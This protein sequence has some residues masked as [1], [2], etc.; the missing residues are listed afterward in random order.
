MLNRW[1]KVKNTDDRNQVQVNPR[2]KN[3]YLVTFCRGEFCLD[4][5]FSPNELHTPS[6]I[7]R[8]DK[9]ALTG[10]IAGLQ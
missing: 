6:L 5:L 10:K 2:P 8:L 4:S 7:V 1:H 3:V 9:G